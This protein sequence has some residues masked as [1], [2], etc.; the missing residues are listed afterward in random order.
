MKTFKDFVSLGEKA[1][2]FEKI[3]LKNIL[4]LRKIP[5]VAIVDSQFVQNSSIRL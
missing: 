1:V 4:E 2:Q 5:N 3:S